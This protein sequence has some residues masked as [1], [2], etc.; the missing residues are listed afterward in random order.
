MNTQKLIDKVILSGREVATKSRSVAE[1]KLKIPKKGVQRQVM[2]SGLGKGA[3]AGGALGFMLG[4]KSGRVLTGGALKVGILVF[5]GVV[6][7]KVY[8]DWQSE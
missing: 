8:K 6:A 5:I 4:T 2:L 1:D 3:L 7:W